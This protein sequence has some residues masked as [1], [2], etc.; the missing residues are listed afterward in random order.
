MRDCTGAHGNPRATTGRPTRSR[1]RVPEAQ[2][3]PL[4]SPPA[5]PRGRPRWG[6]PLTVSSQRIRGRDH[7]RRGLPSNPTRSKSRWEHNE[8]GELGARRGNSRNPNSA[9]LCEPMTF[10]HSRWTQ[11]GRL[12]RAETS[13]T[14]KSRRSHLPGWLFLGDMKSETSGTRIK[15]IDLLF[16]P[17]TKQVHAQGKSRRCRKRTTRWPI[18]LGRFAHPC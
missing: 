10:M 9:F 17:M 5:R 6:G 18:G 7:R 8:T 16:L 3:S 13:Y 12:R 1:L 14:A 11:K 4:P 2:P 15:P